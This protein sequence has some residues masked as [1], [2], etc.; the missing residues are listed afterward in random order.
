MNGWS[1]VKGRI[2]RVVG[3]GRRCRHAAGDK[4]RT[5]KGRDRQDTAKEWEAAATAGAL[6]RSSGLLLNGGGMEGG[7]SPAVGE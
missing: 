6:S 4:C 1:D 2:R 7:P 5:N 3:G